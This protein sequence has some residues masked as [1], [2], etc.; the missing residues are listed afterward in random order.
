MRMCR[1]SV[2]QNVYIESLLC[3]RLCAKNNTNYC[4]G[5]GCYMDICFIS[6]EEVKK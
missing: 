4:N 1:P 6:T 5:E 2:F 3:A